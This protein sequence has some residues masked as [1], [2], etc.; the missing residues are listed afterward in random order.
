[1]LLLSNSLRE[2]VEAR[3]PGGD[4]NPPQQA[5]YIFEEISKSNK[6]ALV[7]SVL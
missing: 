1:M 6:F 4:F 5:C 7:E 3:N 2:T